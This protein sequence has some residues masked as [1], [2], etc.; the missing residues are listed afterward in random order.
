MSRAYR[1][2]SKLHRL[3]TTGSTWPPSYRRYTRYLEAAATTYASALFN[4][5][6]DFELG[7]GRG[8]IA[9]PLTLALDRAMRVRATISPLLEL[10]AQHGIPLTFATVGHLAGQSCSIHN[11]PP[12]SDWYDLDPHTDLSTAP[13]FY[14]QDLLQQILDS[15]VP[16]EIGSHGFAHVDLQDV[17]DSESIVRFEFDESH[18]LIA[19]IDPKVTTFIFPNNHPARLDLLRDAGFTIFRDAH[20]GPIREIIPSLWSFP[21]GLWLSP[22]PLEPKDVIRLLAIAIRRST[23]VNFYFHLHEFDRPATLVR[24]MEPIFQSVVRARDQ[25]ALVVDTVR[26]IISRVKEERS[27]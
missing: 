5:T 19:E 26:G 27:G 15:P 16:H 20:N 25:G 23:L 2:I 21:V 11:E 7:W 13:A 14:A 6:I 9:T 22:V 4:L 1:V 10:S 3:V 17:S 24:F 18:R 12:P 8:T